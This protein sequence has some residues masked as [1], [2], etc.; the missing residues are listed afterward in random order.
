[1]SILSKPSSSA[2]TAVI[3]ITG[4]VLMTVWS[5]IW[6]A[7]LNRNPPS[8]EAIWY[9]CN[10]FILTGIA[11]FVIGLAIGRI[12]RSARHAE[13]PPEEVTAEVVMTDQEAASRA[14]IIASV[15]PPVLTSTNQRSNVVVPALA[16]ARRTQAPPRV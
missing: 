1:M 14:P 2:R 10:G 8:N 5:C 15:N 13:L 11:L 7:Y 4:G 6:Y 12:G 3:Y 9:L 16:P